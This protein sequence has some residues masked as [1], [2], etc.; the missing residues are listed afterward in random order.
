MKYQ[1]VLNLLMAFVLGALC[2]DQR[3]EDPSRELNLTIYAKDVIREFEDYRKEQQHVKDWANRMKNMQ[4][5]RHKRDGTP[6]NVDLTQ[7]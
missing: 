5:E 4:E 1:M 7:N 6:Q 2:A 3:L